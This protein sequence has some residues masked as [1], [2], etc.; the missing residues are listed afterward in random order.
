M[1]AILIRITAASLTVS[2]LLS[3][4]L[5]EIAA[6]QT[7][8]SQPSQEKIGYLALVTKHSGLEV[9][10]DGKFAGFTPTVFKLP[11]GLH[12]V[13]LRHPDRSNWFEEDWSADVRILTGD[14]L[15]VPV[16][17]K[18]SFSINS[19]P[20]GAAIFL[21][22]EAIGET[23]LFF[24]LSE[25]E[26][27]RITLKKEG[28]RD[29]T[30]A[31]GQSEPRFYNIFLEKSSHPVEIFPA[32]TSTELK[33]GSESNLLLYSTLGLTVV[34]GALALYFRKKGNDSYDT[35][36]STGNPDLFNPAYSQAKKFDRLAAVS[37]G[38][39]Q[40]SFVASFYLFL[41]RANK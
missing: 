35:Y 34:S 30:F 22:D 11:E 21:D 37:F 31:I 19:Q 41:K 32:A 17:F 23:P 13:A 10:V 9:R 28:F 29:T 36:L 18:I 27:K 40:V 4:V 8:K 1:T 26:S 6:A 24:K 16:V 38:V 12:K 25:N 7:R 39:F 14:T 3:L 15:R 5:P 2:L 20:F 33:G